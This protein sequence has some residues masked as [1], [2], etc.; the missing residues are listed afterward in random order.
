MKNTLTK[1]RDVGAPVGIS[2]EEILEEGLLRLN[3]FD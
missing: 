3:P 2:I 1:K